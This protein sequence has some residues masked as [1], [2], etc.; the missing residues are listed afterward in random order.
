M[1]SNNAMNP[2]TLFAAF[3]AALDEWNAIYDVEKRDDGSI[4]LSFGF[5]LQGKISRVTGHFEFRHAYVRILAA[6]VI[7]LPRKN[8]AQMLRLVAMVNQNI[9][10]GC[11]EIDLE[12]H[13]LRYRHYLDAEGFSSLPKTLVHNNMLIPFQSFERYGTAFVEVAAGHADAETAFAATRRGDED[14]GEEDEDTPA[15]PPPPEDPP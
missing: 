13:G 11:F 8:L 5:Q 10:A 2:Q 6:P 14:D 1:P 15:P 4:H 7:P 3:Q 12:T 9:Y